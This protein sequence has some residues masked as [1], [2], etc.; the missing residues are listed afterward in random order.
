MIL[1]GC[2]EWI[3]SVMWDMRLSSRDS[4]RVDGCAKIWRSSWRWGN[5]CQQSVSYILY[6]IILRHNYK[7][8]NIVFPL[9]RASAEER[10]GKELVMIARKAGGLCEIKW[11]ALLSGFMETKCLTFWWI[12]REVCVWNECICKF[13]QLSAFHSTLKASLDQLKVRK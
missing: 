6:E 1:Y 8:R 11:V 3:S 7:L 9:G 4:V 5:C 2:R 10:Y 12:E 13:S